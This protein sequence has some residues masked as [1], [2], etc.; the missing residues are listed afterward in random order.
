MQIIDFGKIEGVGMACASKNQMPINRAIQ[1][2]HNDPEN[3]QNYEIL[4][5]E[6]VDETKSL[7]VHSK[8]KTSIDLEGKDLVIFLLQ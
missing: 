4:F 2:H 5:V 1:C 8:D 3:S 7:L 6:K